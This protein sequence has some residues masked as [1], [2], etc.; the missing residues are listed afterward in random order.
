MKK[1]IILISAA[2]F[3]AMLFNSCSKS[4]VTP[5]PKVTVTKPFM[6]FTNNGTVVNYNTCTAADGG[7][8]PSVTLI[9]G[10]N[11]SN[12]TPGDDDIS[13]DIVQNIKTLKAGDVFPA[14]TTGTLTRKNTMVLFYSPDGVNVYAT[15]PGNAVG[16]VTIT[17]VTSTLIGGTFSGKVYA[18]GDIKGTSLKNAITSGTF[19]ASIK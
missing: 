1:I 18:L 19:T 15:A 11:M 8:T 14:T 3:T 5:T 2:A 7:E 10:I 13:I 17:S 16:T 4:P 12:G 9:T 6:K